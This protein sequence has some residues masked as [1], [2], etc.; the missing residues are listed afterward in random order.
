MK[1]SI[2]LFALII[3]SFAFVQAQNEQNDQNDQPIIIGDIEPREEMSTLVN[4]NGSHGIYLGLN[5]NIGQI[6]KSTVFGTSAKLA[7]VIDTKFEIGFQGQGIISALGIANN[8]NEDMYLAAG[9]GGLHLEPILFGRK[10]FHLSFPIFLGGGAVAL[11]EQGDFEPFDPDIDHWEFDPVYQE[12]ETVLVAEPGLNV[13]INVS[14]FLQLEV[15]G[16]Y[17]VSTDMQFTDPA[18]KN[19]NGPTANLGLKIG[20]FDFGRRR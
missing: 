4:R 7:Y 10:T 20:F 19:L 18:I 13:V 1:K 8:G 15:G 12:W 16:R 14:R 3:Q 2:L 9:L 5:S 6:N 17:R 11:Y